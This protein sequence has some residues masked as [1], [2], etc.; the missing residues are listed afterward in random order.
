MAKDIGIDTAC[1]ETLI[2]V[3]FAEMMLDEPVAD[4]STGWRMR[5]TLAVSMLK[6]ADLVLLDEPT[7]HLDE[8]SAGWLCD[9]V[10]SIHYSPMIRRSCP[11]SQRRSRG[12]AGRC[13]RCPDRRCGRRR[14]DAPLRRDPSVYGLRGPPAAEGHHLEDEVEWPLRCRRPE[15]H[16]QDDSHEGG[17][18]PP[19]R[20]HVP[21]L[22]KLCM[23]T[24]RSSAS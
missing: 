18:K 11:P 22:H 8:Q 14:G 17:R 23:W 6:H 4:L 9:Y 2:E 21:E 15:R 12:G 20:P 16:G 13:F 1:R 3:G 7:N 10:N 19:L 5:L 24:T